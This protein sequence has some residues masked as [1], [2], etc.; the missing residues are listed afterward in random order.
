MLVLVTLALYNPLIHAPFLNFDDSS[1]VQ[2]A[3]V[4]SGLSWETIRWA[5]KTRD[6]SNWQPLTWLS[7]ALDVQIFG[8][9]PAG[10]HY[11]NVLFHALNVVLLFLLLE[12]ST[13]AFWRS[14][15]V[16]ALFAVHPVNVE[17]VAWISER[18][19]VL[20]MLF[21]LTGLM[22]YVSYARR[23]SLSR[24]LIAF[25]SFALG[26]MTKPQVITF[27]FVLLLM[28]YWPLDRLD[29]SAREGS[30]APG[31]AFL[32]G[33]LSWLLVEKIPLFVLCAASAVITMKMQTDAIHLEIPLRIRLENALISYVEYLGKAVWPRNLAL[34]YPHPMLSV[35]AVKAAMASVLLIVITIL[36]LIGRKHRYIPFGWF[37]F[38]GTLVPMIGVVQVGVQAMADRYAYIPFIGLFIV[39][40]WGIADLLQARQM[41]VAAMATLSGVALAAFIA[42]SHRQIG[43]WH[44]NLTLWTHT[45]AVTEKN[46]TAEDS[47]GTALIGEDRID[48][49]AQH[50]RNALQ[51][52][53]A[54]P[55]ANLNL[56]FYEQQRGN[57]SDAIP[58]YTAVLRLTSNPLV[59]ATAL[60]DLGY[61]FYELKQYAPAERNFEAALAK[62]PEGARAWIGLGLVAQ[63]S[64]KV[65]QAASLYSQAVRLQP[66][67][68]G[69]LLLAQA[70]DA[71]GE[72][73]AAQVARERAARISADLQGAAE[74]VR[75]LLSE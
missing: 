68:E 63:R 5:F 48:E 74:S 11:V 1:Y 55:I 22:A 8:L 73:Q 37:W 58:R 47:V 50:F 44:D 52:N 69:Y 31:R 66:S 27:P 34:L 26:L 16:A 15:I 4:R 65:S 35:S 10:H 25:V 3:H 14:F 59:L 60:T 20:S 19:N 21:F 54:D 72:N 13:G 61:V 36:A 56:A 64:G 32:K 38:L 39:V 62:V 7:H 53:P 6:L 43:Y 30:E 18:K 49:A 45:L 51:I 71:M 12:R 75:K 23:I 33:P 2:N 29:A 46:F 42:V 24:Y 17:S 40:C 67:D 57:Y 28:D 9:A 70:L 41:P